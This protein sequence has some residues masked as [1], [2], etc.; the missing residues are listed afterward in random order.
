VEKDPLATCDLGFMLRLLPEARVI[1]AL[2]DP[3]DVCVSFFFTLLPL[4]PDSSPALDLASACEAAAVSLRLWKHWRSV[5]P[6]AWAEV[7]YERLVQAPRD[8]LMP[9]MKML[10]L[11]W[12]ERMLARRAP[13]KMRAIRSPTYA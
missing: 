1:F 8:E 4:N 6:Q 2:R 13:S 9:L 12:D 11:P 7:R 3:R 5:M 10:E